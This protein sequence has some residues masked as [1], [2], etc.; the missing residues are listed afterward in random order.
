MGALR[1]W[2]TGAR[3]VVGWLRRSLVTAFQLAR[4]S[5][6]LVD[7][8]SSGFGGFVQVSGVG[9]DGER[10]AVDL[11]GGY[12]CPHCRPCPT[13]CPTAD[14]FFDDAPLDES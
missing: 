3:G 5:T 14:C 9:V 7:G 10:C 1:V 6:Q 2:C 11:K 13:G 4:F 12:L 8:L